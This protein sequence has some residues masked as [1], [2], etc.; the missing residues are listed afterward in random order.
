MTGVQLDMEIV[1]NQPSLSRVLFSRKSDEWATPQDLFDELDA[2]FH[3]DIDACAS[4]LNHKCDEYYTKIRDG[5]TAD[6]RGKT[7]FCN[8]P[9]SDIARWVE[10]CYREGTKDNTTVVLLIPSRTDTTYFHNF[11]YHRAEIR[12]VGG[13]L[14]FEGAKWNAPFPS[15]IVIFRGAYS[16]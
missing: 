13:R 14:K 10:K 8:P 4:D 5:L 16:I 12:F 2:E 9:Y 7:V 3:F 11:I 6:W 1:T 15:M